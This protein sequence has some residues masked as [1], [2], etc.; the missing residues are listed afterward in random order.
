[1]L[2]LI[3]R[4]HKCN[5]FH[6]ENSLREQIIKAIEL[7]KK[8]FGGGE[9]LGKA[10]DP[11]V[12]GVNISRWSTGKYLPQAK[13]L[14][15]LC[16]LVGARLVLPDEEVIT[17]ARIR[18]LVDT[19]L[20]QQKLVVENA[21]NDVEPLTDYVVK[22]KYMH[23]KMLFHPDYLRE[24]NVEAQNCFL[25]QIYNDNMLPT[26]RDGD[27]VLADKTLTDVSFTPELFV[28]LAE[29][30]LMVRWLSRV[31]GMLRVAQ[32]SGN[33]VIELPP[34]RQSSIHIL[35]K[36]VWTSGRVV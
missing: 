26:L 2:N 9:G 24:L 27:Q 31:G 23:P 4:L 11:P 3:L 6:M 16:D 19:E 8:M 20:V 32:E 30:N 1:M 14:E 17:F 34:E 25:F 29:E 15:T 36:V 28:I 22:R 7:G 5:V 21:Q 12:S 33:R 18:Q 10:C 13:Q 35:G